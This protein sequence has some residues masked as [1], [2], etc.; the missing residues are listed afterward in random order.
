LVGFLGAT[1]LATL[2]G[3]CGSSSPSSSTFDAG[4][5]DDA[6]TSPDGAGDDGSG[7]GDDGSGGFHQG[8]GASSSGGGIATMLVFDPPQTTLVLDGVHPQSTTFQLM[9]TVGGVTRAVTP[10]ALQFDRPDLAT[11]MSGTTITVTAAGNYGG[12]GHLEGVFGGLAA[13]AELDLVVV[14]KNLG[15]GVSQTVASA[16]DMASGGTGADAGVPAPSD[17]AVTS[18]LYPYDKTVFPLGLTSP[19]IMWN[20]PTGAGHANDVYRLRLA[21]KAFTYDLYTTVTQPAQVRV[22]Q[23]AWARI[24]ASNGGASDPLQVILSRYDAGSQTAAVSVVNSWTIAPASL[25]GAIYYWTAS[26]ATSSSARIGYITRLSAGN[27]ATPQQ[28]N[29]GRCMGCHAVSAD[30]TT[31]VASIDDP[32]TAPAAPPYVLSWQSPNYTRP[33]ASFDVSQAAAP[34]IYQSKEY[35]ADIAVTPDGKYTVWGAPTAVAGSKVLSLSDTH[36]GMLLT[37]SGLDALLTPLN[38]DALMM[39][40]FSPDGS[41]LAVVRS[42]QGGDNVLPPNPSAIDYMSLTII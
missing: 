33:W 3:A 39:P 21:E 7:T 28:L 8:D 40:A 24:T 30:G 16:I 12:T 18:L 13:T 2:I 42:S 22:D 10:T 25:A 11:V 14:Q 17:T 4:T 1:G 37:N 19:L 9:A 26:Q 15:T 38:G 35:G 27:G 5:G 41:M 36:S 20:A 31:L 6:T 29:S 23:A 32:A 34:L